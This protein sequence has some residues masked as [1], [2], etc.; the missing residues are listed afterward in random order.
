MPWF[1]AF[2]SSQ[3]WLGNLAAVGNDWGFHNFV[4]LGPKYVTALGF[5]LKQVSEPWG[6]G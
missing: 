5:D 2:K 4:T 6:E 3:F 1:A